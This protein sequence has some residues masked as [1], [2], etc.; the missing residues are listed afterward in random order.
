MGERNLAPAILE[1]TLSRG[2]AVEMA[3]GSVIERRREP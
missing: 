1:R 2:L 3:G